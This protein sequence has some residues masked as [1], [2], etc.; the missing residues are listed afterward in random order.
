M[1]THERKLKKKIPFSLLTQNRN[2]ILRKNRLNF[3]YKQVFC[4]Y[5]LKFN[6]NEPQVPFRTIPTG[7]ISNEPVVTICNESHY[8]LVGYLL[9]WIW[10]LANNILLL[11]VQP[12]LIVFLPNNIS[13]L[14]SYLCIIH[15]RYYY[16]AQVACLC[17]DLSAFVVL[18]RE[19]ISIPVKA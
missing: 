4:S 5:K 16:N 8:V 3:K 15:I 7:T 11:L 2:A 10:G 9:I 19:R 6:V 14:T 12:I 1:L 17:N 18:L 13:Y